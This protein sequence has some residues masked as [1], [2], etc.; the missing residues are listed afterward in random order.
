D[1]V[2]EMIPIAGGTFTMGSPQGEKGRGVNEGPQF[3]VEIE[4]FWMGKHEVTWAEYKQF[5]GLYDAFKKFVSKKIRVVTKDNVIDAITA[6]TKLYDPSHTFEK[7]EHPR[8][9]AVTMTQ[10]A[11]KQY[12][13]WLSAISGSFHRLPSEAEWEYACRAGT[14]TTYSFGDDP[15]KLGDYAWYSANSKERPQHVGQKK[16]NPWGLHDMHGNAAEWTLD[17]Q[18]KTGYKKFMGKKVS[19]K[20]AIVWPTKVDPR[21]IRGGSWEFDPAGC[22]SASRLGSQVEDWK[23]EDP[24]LPL[25]PWWFT[26]DP[27]RGVGMRLFRPLNEPDDRQAKEKFWKADVEDVQLDV[28]DRIKEGRGAQGLVDKDLPKAIKDLK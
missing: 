13:K 27:A 14:D 3:T 17:Q 1:V 7:G 16:P 26:S 2:F 5:M 11:A 22:R 4:P 12:T 25:S 18:L 19:W 8:Q 6:P 20:A 21:S 9:P 23:D 24:N 10:Y 15:A 28:A